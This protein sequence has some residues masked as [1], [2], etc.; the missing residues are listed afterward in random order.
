MRTA[1]S[2]RR[3][4][5]AFAGAAGLVLLAAMP[6][7][8]HVTVSSPDAAPGGFG[9]LV[10]RVPNE[11]DTATTTKLQVQLPTDTPFAS[12]STKPMPGWTVDAEPTK[13]P[14]PVDVNG[15]TVTEAVTSV[16]WT[17]QSGGG[18]APDQF[19][20]FEISVGPFP[21]DV[22][23]MSFP[24]TQTYDD[25]EVVR[26]SQPVD[27]DASEAEEPEHP[28]PALELASAGE[29]AH[30]GHGAGGAQQPEVTEPVSSTSAASSSDSDTVARTLGGIAVVLAAVALA[31][32]LLAGR[33]TRG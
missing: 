5:A 9:K 13:L 10:F 17:A 8:A 20:E 19:D 33:R 7:S 22:E 14:E 18:I 23:A 25:G 28:A 12:V 30:D 16:T 15:A 32:S 1:L 27:P 3:V 29:T 4:A 26:W 21:E 11:S 24:A 31:R 6:A 2:T